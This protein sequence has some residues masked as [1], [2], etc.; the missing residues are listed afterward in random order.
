MEV[1][2]FRDWVEKSPY[3]GFCTF[4]VTGPGL[5]LTSY[6]LA[7]ELKKHPY[8]FVLQAGIA[9]S[10]HSTLEVGNVYQI[11][12][13]VFGDFGARDHHNFLDVFELGLLNPNDFPFENGVLN[14]PR[15]IPGLSAVKGVT[16][17]TASGDEK[18]IK[19][20]K[21]EF[22][23]DIETMEGGPLFFICLDQKMP[24]CQIRSISNFIEPRNKSA[25]NIPLSVQNLNQTLIKLFPS[26][27]LSLE[28][29]QK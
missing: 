22:S 11:T 17:N 1:L 21:K 18:T 4:L 9:G 3:N 27:L 26:L 25:W 10:F 12:Q 29:A 8:D 20:L 16:V 15:L 14:N 19:R 5:F 13:E 23:P 6:R 28:S 7:Q 2:K 24:F